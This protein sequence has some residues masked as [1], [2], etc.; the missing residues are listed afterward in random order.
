MPLTIT[1]EQKE[2]EEEEKLPSAKDL[3][4]KRK[5]MKMMAKK[6]G[7][8]SPSKMDMPKE[9]YEDEDD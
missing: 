4:M 2:Y 8:K 3:A 1:I 6:H 7:K 9:E 5:A